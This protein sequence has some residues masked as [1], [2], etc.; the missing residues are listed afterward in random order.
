MSRQ[1]LNECA[2]ELAPKGVLR[3]AINLSNFLL[4]SGQ[5]ET[6]EPFGVA[7]DMAKAIG[8]ALNIP[9]KLVPYASPGEVVD[10]ASQDQWDLCL[11][12]AEPARAEI[13]SFTQAYV[14]ILATYLV[15]AGSP[16][17]TIGDV[18]Q[19]GV[20]IAVAERAA[21]DLWLV[22]NIKQASLHHAQG[23]DAAFDL[24]VTEKL[25]ALACLKPRL[26]SDVEKL[27]GSRILDGQ[28]TSV[29]QAVG[30]HKTNIHAAD[31]LNGFVKQAITSGFVQSLIEKHTVK[32]LSVAPV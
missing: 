23:I 10:A 6:G 1:T 2:A 28:F 21:Y 13:I 5:H 16:L 19:P 22:A 15:P 9:V 31:F 32:G 26:L 18:D 27:P 4:V 7:P 20:R 17:K 8:A 24:F 29:Q 25:E 3:A 12:G 30:T 11:I 14:E